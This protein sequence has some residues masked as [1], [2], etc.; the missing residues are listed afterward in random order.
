MQA[1]TTLLE[2]RIKMLEKEEAKVLKKIHSTRSRADQIIELTNANEKK[3]QEKLE[4]QKK[5]IAD[6]EA[7]RQRFE[8]E[9]HQRRLN[10][11]M[12]KNQLHQRHH[13]E[14]VQTRVERDNNE[15]TVKKQKE[16]HVNKKRRMR[17]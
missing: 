6:R 16:N 13:Q 17:S 7:A 4:A 5:R 12:K 3:F 11:E 8:E 1:D 15:D 9:R 10:I 2:N 14:F